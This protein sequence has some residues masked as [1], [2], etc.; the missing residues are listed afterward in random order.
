MRAI[1]LLWPSLC[2]PL[3]I[4]VTLAPDPGNLCWRHVVKMRF[5]RGALVV[6]LCSS[7]RE[8]DGLLELLNLSLE[9][10]DHDT[11][12]RRMRWR[13]LLGQCK[14]QGAR[15]WFEEC[16]VQAMWN[17]GIGGAPN[18]NGALR[19]GGTRS[20]IT[21]HGGTVPPGGVDD[22]AHIS[23]RRKGREGVASGAL[24]TWEQRTRRWMRSRRWRGNLQRHVVRG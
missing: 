5:M 14:R 3:S 8:L 23:S 12:W 2:G 21:R 4:E 16:S 13:L 9:C 6:G 22:V 19:D 24:R 1:S 17:T 10:L 15:K 18:A 20:D 7:L 11:L